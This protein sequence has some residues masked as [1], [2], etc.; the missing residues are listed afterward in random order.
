MRGDHLEVGYRK[1]VIV[2]LVNDAVGY[3][4][5]FYLAVSWSRMIALASSET[6]DSVQI[7]VILVQ[8]CSAT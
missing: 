2:V 1:L 3:P 5:S 8:E 6:G 7:V 4:G